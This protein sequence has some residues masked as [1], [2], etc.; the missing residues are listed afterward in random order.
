VG[1]LQYGSSDDYW[2]AYNEAIA[3]SQLIAFLWW[4]LPLLFFYLLPAILFAIVVWKR[5]RAKLKRDRDV[6]IIATLLMWPVGLIL[7]A[8]LK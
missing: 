6:V 3:R 1:L 5:P 2:R 8:L 7:W 4:F